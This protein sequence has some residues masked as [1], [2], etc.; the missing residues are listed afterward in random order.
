MSPNAEPPDPCPPPLGLARSV[1]IA[2][3]ERRL[4]AAGWE[5]RAG[6]VDGRAG[7]VWVVVLS[8][9]YRWC[10]AMESSREGAWRKAMR[11]TGPGVGP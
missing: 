10:Y 4:E 7:D 5:V 8:R 11:W 2:E 3:L 9:G 6:L 1:A